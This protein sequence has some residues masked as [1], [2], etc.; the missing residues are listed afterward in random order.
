MVQEAHLATLALEVVDN[1]GVLVP[2]IAALEFYILDMLPA[3]VVLGMPF[4]WHCN[5]LVDWIA[6]TIN[7]SCFHVL[8]LLQ[9]E[10]APIEVCL[11]W[12]LLKTIRK[13][14]VTAWLCLLQPMASCLAMGVSK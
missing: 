14:H 12:C 5:P 10:A 8:A 7:F 1:Q 3:S 6:C 9:H 4:L 11:L 13:A 2:V